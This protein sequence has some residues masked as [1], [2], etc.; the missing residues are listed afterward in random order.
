MEK[1]E[2]GLLPFVVFVK[3]PLQFDFVEIQH[4]TKFFS[5]SL[6]FYGSPNH[7]PNRRL[8]QCLLRSSLRCGN[9]RRRRRL[10]SLRGG[11]RVAPRSEFFQVNKNSTFLG[12]HSKLSLQA[13]LWMNCNVS[14]T[15]K[16]LTWV[17]DAKKSW[18]THA[19]DSSVYRIPKFCRHNLTGIH[20]HH[21][22]QMRMPVCT[23]P[24]TAG[25]VKPIVGPPQNSH[26]HTSPENSGHPTSALVD[27]RTLWCSPPAVRIWWIWRCTCRW[28]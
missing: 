11:L 9:G 5:K 12:A 4:V 20:T 6:Q 23:C 22:T 27:K 2:P 15:S 25:R 1:P 18:Y 19:I 21:H 26:L 13:H 3:L 28:S 7:H 10:Q 8:V 14:P 24:S 17:Y 16:F